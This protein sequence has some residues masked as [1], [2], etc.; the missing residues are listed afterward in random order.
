MSDD[1]LE[2]R[3][4]HPTRSGDIYTAR[5]S[6]DCTAERAVASLQSS[7]TGPFLAPAPEGQP[8]VL[9][10]DKSKKELTPSTTMR[11]A[12]VASGDLLRV[13]QMHQGA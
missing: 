11:Q 10:H 3:F 5:V 8:Y 12:Q 4:M 1:R 7:K 9:V 2:V 13:T 6:G